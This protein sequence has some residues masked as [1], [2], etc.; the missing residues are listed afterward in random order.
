M[1]LIMLKGKFKNSFENYLEKVGKFEAKRN[2][3]ML[4]R[5]ISPKDKKEYIKNNLVSK[6]YSYCFE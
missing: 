3:E 6:E 1:S 4:E 5:G 2:I